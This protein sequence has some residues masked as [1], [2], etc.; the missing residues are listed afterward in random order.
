MRRRDKNDPYEGEYYDFDSTPRRKS[1]K[2]CLFVIIGIACVLILWLVIAGG[3]RAQQSPVLSLTPVDSSLMPTVPHTPLVITQTPTTI[4]QVNPEITPTPSPHEENSQEGDIFNREALVKYMLDLVNSDRQA[5]GLGLVV[6]DDFASA[7][8]QAHAEEMAEYNYLSHWN[9]AGQGPDIRYGLAGG[10]DVVMENVYSYYQRYDDGVPVPV[11]DWRKQVFDAQRSL[12]ESPGH[13]RN[14]LDPN[15]THVGVG[16]AYNPITGELRIA[17][18]FLNRYVSLQSSQTEVRAGDALVVNGILLPGLSAAFSN[19]LF[20]PYP[21]PLTVEQLNQTATY[22]SPAVFLDATQP[23]IDPE[24]RFSIEIP[25][26]P[27]AKPGLYHVVIWVEIEAQ[28]VPAADVIFT[29]D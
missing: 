14:I 17:Q 19:L 20:E 22:E 1:K 8:G 13:R 12:M 29:L 28:N 5:N 11:Y 4:I 2:G 15:H 24:G 7:V 16:I 21:S 3:R 6:L 10:V 27:E 18:E 26:W 25:I 23:E 9:L